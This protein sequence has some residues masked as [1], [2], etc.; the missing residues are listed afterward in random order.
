MTAQDV[1]P[2]I[3]GD[4]AYNTEWNTM[5]AGGL[6][7]YTVIDA[8]MENAMNIT[9]LQYCVS[10]TDILHDYMIVD[11]FTRNCGYN[12]TLCV[13]NTTSTYA[14]GNC[15]LNNFY[16]NCQ[17]TT[18]NGCQFYNCC[19]LSSACATAFKTIGDYLS[20]NCVYVNSGVSTVTGHQIQCS[21]VCAPFSLVGVTVFGFNASCIVIG[22][23]GTGGNGNSVAAHC[24]S[25]SVSGND[26]S[27]YTCNQNYGC[28][29]AISHTYLCVLN[30]YKYVY[31][32][33]NCWCFYCNDI[34]KCQVT[35]AAFPNIVV[36]LNM[37]AT[38]FCASGSRLCSC[39][40]ITSIYAT[41]GNCKIQTN[42]V[43]WASAI[44]TTYLDL[45][46]SGEGTVVYNVINA[47]DNACLCC[48]LLPKC[49]YTMTCCVPCQRYEIV[50]CADNLS[51]IKSYA[52]AVGV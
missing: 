22:C 31:V 51:C 28:A 52:I 25:Y 38:A 43:T 37:C 17:A 44:K 20:T 35:S 33:A 27:T 36:S 24:I 50:Q 34:A 3:S 23:I 49:L 4:C 8:S 19:S 47:A 29:T 48:N 45:N 13:E 10:L 15:C 12:A 30:C 32:S 14:A 39:Y 21:C 11:S 42:N 41:C 1:F 7:G 5:Y 40:C 6:A 26:N 9:R 16:I 18:I 46:K 2:K